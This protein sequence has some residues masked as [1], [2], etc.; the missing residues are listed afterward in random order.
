M[1][2]IRLGKFD[3]GPK[4]ITVRGTPTFEEWAAVGEEIADYE[5][6]S[7]FWLGDWLR[8]GEDTFHELASQAENLTGYA[9][10]YLKNLRY[11]AQNVSLSRR[12]DKVPF[13]AHSEV[14]SLIP[15]HQDHWLRWYESQVPLP[16]RIAM[17]DAVR[18]W[19]RE[20]V[21]DSMAEM[22]GK[23][24]VVYADPPWQYND[25]GP[26]APGEPSRGKA[27]DHFPTM[28]IEDICKIPVA[29]HVRPN[30]VL[31]LWTTA[32]LLLQ[33]P[34]P[35]EVIEAW[36]FDAK[37]GIVWDK[38]ALGREGVRQLAPTPLGLC[39][40]SSTTRRIAA[41]TWF[42]CPQTLTVME[43]PTSPHGIPR[44][45][46]GS[47]IPPATAIDARV[48]IAWV[49]ARASRCLPT[50]TVTGLP[51]LRCLSQM[52]GGGCKAGRFG[53]SESVGI[54]PCRATMTA[55]AR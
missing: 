39:V 54:F 12:R 21:V 48:V 22:R 11:V 10:E 15:A 38:D 55:T 53:N 45:G 29:A 50:T 28:P 24:R 23:Y 44:T 37:T 18:V 25:S 13:W 7:P 2:T 36:G 49:R 52:A 42:Q 14:S 4:G 16:K 27:E 33:N 43:R 46:R 41:R 6:Y 17:R 30:S 19:K 8:I 26:S 1:K 5:R 40:R 3:L 20:T 31:F 47:S 51:R 32:P 34:G 35:R 9:Y